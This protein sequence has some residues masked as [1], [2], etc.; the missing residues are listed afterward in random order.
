MKINSYFL[1]LLFVILFQ[2]IYSMEIF[3]NSSKALKVFK[4]IE[5]K[6]L[7][8]NFYYKNF[9]T[10]SLINN[11]FR[12]LGIFGASMLGL[13]SFTLYKKKQENTKTEET[14]EKT[15][16]ITALD[17]ILNGIYQEEEELRKKKLKLLIKF[18]EY[19]EW[20]IVVKDFEENKKKFIKENN[21]D[22]FFEKARNI[23]NKIKNKDDKKAFLQK[24]TDEIESY[25]FYQTNLKPFEE[26]TKNLPNKYNEQ[27]TLNYYL[28]YFNFYIKDLQFY[29]L[30]D[31]K[32]T[33][34]DLN[35]INITN[36]IENQK[37]SNIN[38]VILENNI[39]SPYN[40]LLI[41]SNDPID[42]MKNEENKKY[43]E[44]INK[45]EIKFKDLY[46]KE[47][48]VTNVKAINKFINFS[49][50]LFL[51]RSKLNNIDI[52]EYSKTLHEIK[53]NK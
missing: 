21:Y 43:K 40:F 1:K 14:E 45:I 48:L 3:T 28:Y 39:Y 16:L 26:L 36:F 46:G 47:K 38:K 37:F 11:K 50:D 15:E 2:N 52:K 53:H 27:K 20:D 29:P 25:S 24:I 18:I 22:I 13:F 5:K 42:E 10:E 23:F 6:D 51:T 8:L 17:S 30:A 49:N 12:L 19:F 33:F 41:I 4:L 34:S 31:P 35:F 32:Q 9:T 44:Y 7:I